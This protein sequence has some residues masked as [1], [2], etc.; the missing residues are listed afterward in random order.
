MSFFICSTF[1][2]G[3]A[4]QTGLPGFITSD[5]IKGYYHVNEQ[6]SI[7]IASAFASEKVVSTTK[8]DSV[9]N[10]LIR[11]I[12]L[13]YSRYHKSENFKQAPLNEARWNNLLSEYPTLFENGTTHYRNICQD[14]ENDTTAKKLPHGFY[15]Y[16]ENPGDPLKRDREISGI[17]KL[18]QSMGIDTSDFL[19]EDLK[20][21]DSSGMIPVSGLSKKHS[22]F[23]KPMHARDSKACR[24][25]FYQTGIK[26]LDAFFR[27]KIKL[28]RFQ[29]IRPGKL[30]TEIRLTL[31][32]NGFI[33]SA[34]VLCADKLL[35]EQIKRALS[36]ME[37]WNPAVRNG[38]TIKA[39]VKFSLRYFPDGTLGLIGGVTVPYMLSK[40]G[41][42]S[43]DELFDFNEKEMGEH[44]LPTVF[45]VPDKSLLRDVIKRQPGLNNILL[46]VDLTGSMGPYI[47][48]VLE[49]MAD[50][51]T[52]DAP[53]VSC[54]SLFNDGDSKPDRNKVIGRTQGITVLHHDI[55]LETLGKAILR[56]MKNGTGGD[57]MENNIEAVIKG[58]DKCS[59][60]KDIV[61]IADNFATPRDG[62]L[63]KFVTFPIHWIL[64]GVENEINVRYMDLVRANK[65][66]LHTGKSDISNLHLLK[67]NEIIEIEGYNYALRSG[68][69][70]LLTVR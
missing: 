20:M 6:P 49:L 30:D 15:I 37:V 40:C 12:V 22:K 2:L 23:K 13:V 56:S 57:C 68:K 14:L 67:E 34:F 17:T 38:L 52:N 33:K 8:L 31:D 43:D 39:N 24:Q 55:T 21:P 62:A 58:M 19:E 5:T 35:I 50:L 48:Q 66:V 64:C 59:E 27:E 61:M 46:V 18:V 63:L 45:E 60:C 10:F 42:A 9:R 44:A 41:T 16:F 25:P 65:G 54:I 26:D 32:F 7:F 28:T 36:E 1:T 69:F 53:H 3:L 47:A 70:R 29:K 51:V 11:E 4:A